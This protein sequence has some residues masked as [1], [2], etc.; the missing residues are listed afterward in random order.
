LVTDLGFSKAKASFTETPFLPK[1]ETGMTKTFSQ[2]NEILMF[3][4]FHFKQCVL[5]DNI[6]LKMLQQFWDHTVMC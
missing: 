3:G 1:F 4:K 6:F 5:T 2:N